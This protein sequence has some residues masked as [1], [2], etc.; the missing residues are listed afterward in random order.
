MEKIVITPN[1]ETVDLLPGYI[2]RRRIEL[3]VVEKALA[4]HDFAGLATIGHNVKGTAGSY[5][6]SGLGEF[7]DQLYTAAVNK[8]HEACR[9]A[10]EGYREYLARVEVGE[11]A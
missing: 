8:N 2:D 5:G 6:I 10:F 1:E 9:L 7:A 4:A 3:A 11:M